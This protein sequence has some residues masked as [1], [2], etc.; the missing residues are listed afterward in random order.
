MQA[1][2]EKAVTTFGH[3]DCLVNNAGD[4]GPTKPVQDYLAGGLALHDRLLPDELVP[5]RAL[6]R[7]G[8]DQG[9][10]RR[11]RQHRVD[12]GAPRTGV[13]RRLL[14]GEGRSDRA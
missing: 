5:L 11:D 3:L 13:S 2:V 14:L 6:R 10:P 4:G 1:L 7:A 12:G 8:D 9:G